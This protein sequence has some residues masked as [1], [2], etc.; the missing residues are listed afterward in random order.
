MSFFSFEGS[1]CYRLGIGFYFVEFACVTYRLV[2]FPCLNF[3]VSCLSF[4]CFFFFEPMSIFWEIYF[5]HPFV[6][7]V[8]IIVWLRRLMQILFVF[9][10]QVLGVGATA[11][12]QEIRKAYHKLALRLHP[13][14]NKDDEVNHSSLGMSVLH[15]SNKRKFEFFVF[16]YVLNRK[17]RRS[18]SSCRRWYL[19][20]VMKRRELSMIKLAPLMM[21]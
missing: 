15:V 14:K 2:M 1:Y 3:I 11:T 4:T 6:L 19:F 5:Y 17:L 7:L 21:L 9:L 20:S 12:Q 8:V 13:D 10:L 18:F 16:F